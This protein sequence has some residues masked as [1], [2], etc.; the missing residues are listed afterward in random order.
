MYNGKISSKENKGTMID[1]H[2]HLEN[3]ELSVEYCM[4]FVKEAQKKGITKLHILD[5]THRFQEFSFM[6]DKLKEI[7]QQKIWLQNKLKDSLLTYLGLIEEMK[8]K[9]LPIEVCFGL[10]VCYTPQDKMFLKK[11]LQN[12]SFD[13]L[14]GSI[15]SIDGKLYDMPF[16]KEILWERED[17]D[18]IYQRYFKIMEDMIDSNL[19]TQIGHPDQLKLFHYAPSYNLLPTYTRIAKAAKEHEVFMEN[20]T[21]I[22]YRYGHEDIGTNEQFLSI[23]RNEGVKI[24]TAS[25]AHFPSDV[26]R[27]F[28][29][30]K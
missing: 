10:E 18:T 24:I 7:T 20:N 28:E 2:V 27:C 22:H 6:Y 11:F 1:G 26:G 23:L 8:K 16:S 19:F 14:V 30:I 9:D 12:Y 3:G 21:G 29:M 5:H 25:D 17:I 15:H 13:F 4:Q